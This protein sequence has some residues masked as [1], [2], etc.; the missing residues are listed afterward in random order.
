MRASDAPVEP[1]VRRQA[2][3][4][5]TAKMAIEGL[6]LRRKLQLESVAVELLASGFNKH[7]KRGDSHL[8]RNGRCA[9]ARPGHETTSVSSVQCISP[10]APAELHS[11]MHLTVETEREEDG[12]W[13][14]EISDLAGV[15]AYG[16][17]RDQAIARAEALALRVLADRLEN[18]E[19]GPDLVSVSFRAA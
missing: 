15:L 14:A 18:A 13:I 10:V 2:T 19:A 6:R 7:R 1:R 11:N 3:D 17:T 12:R 9:A 5:A 16:E 8:A 4:V